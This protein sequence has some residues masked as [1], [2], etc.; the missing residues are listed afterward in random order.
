MLFV[1][2]DRGLVEVEVESDA[3]ASFIGR[4]HHRIRARLRGDRNALA[5]FEKKR[6]TLGGEVFVPETD[7][8]VLVSLYYAG[9]LDYQDPYDSGFVEDQHDA[10]GGNDVAE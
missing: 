2:R 9:E 8:Q 5:D 6:L 10:A 3:V 7:L 4:H 1:D